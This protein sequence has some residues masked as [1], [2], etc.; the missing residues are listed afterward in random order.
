LSPLYGCGQIAFTLRQ[1]E[2]R[3]FELRC[4]YLQAPNKGD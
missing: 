3:A 4:A 2:G 1:A